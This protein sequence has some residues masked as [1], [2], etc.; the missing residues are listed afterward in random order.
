M[1]NWQ[2]PFRGDVVE[3]RLLARI[4]EKLP[5]IYLWRRVL[6][7]DDVCLTSFEAF[8]TYLKKSILVSFMKSEGLVLASSRDEGD[9]T[10]RADF[11][12]IGGVEIGRGELTSAKIEQLHNFKS[13]EPRVEAYRFLL[14][15]TAAFGP[16]VYVGETDCLLSRIRQ[17][18]ANNSPLRS[19]FVGLG[20]ELDQAVLYYAPM[21]GTTK[22]FRQ[23]YE[24]VLTHLFVAPL[25]FRPG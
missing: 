14:D 18:C 19:R 7:L 21:P 24:Q 10:I 6:P 4:K 3:N 20:I 13:L 9:V 16:V 11:V 5:C 8:E 12:R 23:L 17:H 22:A 1:Q 2:G 25:T 15:S